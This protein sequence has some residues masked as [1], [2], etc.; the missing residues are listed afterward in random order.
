MPRKER[1]Y[2]AEH[3]RRKML[4]K[5]FSVKLSWEKAE[6]LDAKIALEPLSDDGKQT[7]RN[8]LIRKWIDMYLAGQLD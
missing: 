2:K 8:A 5:T 4:E 6:A 3:E 1:D 7:T